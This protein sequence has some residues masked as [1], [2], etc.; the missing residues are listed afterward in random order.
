MRLKL[1]CGLMLCVFAC[2][3]VN[4]WKQPTEL[5]FDVVLSQTHAIDQRVQ[6]TGG[7]LAL[8]QFTLEGKR[9]EGG[10][11]FFSNTY[12][13]AARISIGENQ[14]PA[15]T[16]DVPQGDYTQL[17]LQWEP[18]QRQGA[19][20]VLEGTYQATDGV[21]SP[22][23]IELPAPEAFEIRHAGLAAR[24]AQSLTIDQT[25]GHIVLEVGHWLNPQMIEQLDR[26][27]QVEENGTF[28]LLI[29]QKHN[30]ALYERIFATFSK[31]T[32]YTWIET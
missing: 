12:D 23:R 27:D 19:D 22:L 1:L 26:A 9:T 15:L 25:K 6:F 8:Q 18:R 24:A 13:P 30:T 4:Q 20:V 11:V 7:E 31:I 29:S 14:T 2:S 3:K 10:D 28:V 32:Q 16:F 21:V 5:S 17:N